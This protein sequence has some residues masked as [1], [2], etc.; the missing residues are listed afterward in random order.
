MGKISKIRLEHDN[1]KGNEESSWH[2]EK[3]ILEN[4]LTGDEL[5]FKV[6][7]WLS[8]VEEEGNVA[9]ELAAEWP[10]KDPLEGS[11]NFLH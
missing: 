3:V 10:D 7:K 8:A 4:L 6:D 11:Y 9:I 5:E 1:G 2:V